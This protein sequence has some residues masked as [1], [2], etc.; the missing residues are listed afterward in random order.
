MGR[1]NITNPSS[2]LNE[3]EQE[4][5]K[6]LVANL[7]GCRDVPLSKDPQL[8]GL[9]RMWRGSSYYR[10]DQMSFGDWLQVEVDS[11]A[12]HHAVANFEKGYDEG[13]QDAV[14][15]QVQTFGGPT[16]SFSEKLRGSI[17]QL[18]I[19]LC[20]DAIVYFSLRLI[21]DSF[22]EEGNVFIGVAVL[23]ICV[24]CLIAALLWAYNIVAWFV[25]GVEDAAKFL[26]DSFRA[27]SERK[28]CVG[29][30]ERSP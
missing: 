1:R 9:L 13:Y 11:S 28:N 12:S 21:V 8:D 26:T 19:F 6:A 24:L 4:A 5:L 3:E 23:P 10:D 17:W 15:E 7:R 18:V 22:S 30:E 16:K 27:G 29:E 25:L 2:D 14:L 20:L